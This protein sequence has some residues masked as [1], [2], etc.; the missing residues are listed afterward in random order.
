VLDAIEEEALEEALPDDEFASVACPY[1]W[2]ATDVH[3]G[4]LDG[5]A[6]FVEDCEVCCRPMVLRVEGVGDDV[7]VTAEREAD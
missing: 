5:A 7:E 4:L 2:Q 6:E 1:C 3:L